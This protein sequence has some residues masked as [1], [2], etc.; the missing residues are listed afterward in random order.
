M[1]IKLD[2]KLFGLIHPFQAYSRWSPTLSWHSTTQSSLSDG[3]LFR[4]W[5]CEMLWA[6]MVSL[7]S[8]G[9][10]ESPTIRGK[11]EKNISIA[12]IPLPSWE[13]FSKDTPLQT[14][15]GEKGTECYRPKM[16][17]SQTKFKEEFPLIFQMPIIQWLISKLSHSEQGWHF[18]KWLILVDNFYSE[19][20]QLSTKTN[21]AIKP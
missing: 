3:Q 21:T 7:V 20:N 18:R 15:Y 19:W 4:F 11:P 9:N 2:L 17:V 12:V 6:T 13:T 5:I 1:K 10:R 14:H 8:L 16:N